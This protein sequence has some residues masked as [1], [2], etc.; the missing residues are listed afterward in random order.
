MPPTPS[1][2][3]PVLQERLRRIDA[4]L[5]QWQQ[6][7]GPLLG[8]GQRH[9]LTGL[10]QGGGPGYVLTNTAQGDDPDSYAWVPLAVAAPTPAGID[11]GYLGGL[12]DDDHTQ[13][14]LADGSRDLTGNLAVDAGIT[15]DGVDISAHAADGDAHHLES[16]TVAS[17]SDTTATGPE[18]NTL[19]DGFDAGALHIHDARYFTE[20]EHLDSSAGAGDAGKPIKLDAGGKVD[21]SMINDADIDHGSIGGLSDDDHT[22]YTKKATLTTTGDLYYASAASTPARLAIGSTYHVLQVSGGV[23]TW[24]L[25]PTKWRFHAPPFYRQNPTTADDYMWTWVPYAITMLRV[26]AVIVGGTSVTFQIYRRSESSPGSGGTAVMSASLTATTSGASTASF[27]ASG[28]VA[29]DQWLAIDVSAVS[30][31]VTDMWAYLEASI[32]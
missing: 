26:Y 16:H 4:K 24:G 13:Y 31:S 32:D 29:A 1:Q 28:A 25:L 5:N 9:V 6:A 30:G 10:M 21:D 15:I 18:L 23:P 12:D 7:L 8:S 20:S 27:A 2:S 3:D 14:L 22:Q 17:H 19:T 11:H